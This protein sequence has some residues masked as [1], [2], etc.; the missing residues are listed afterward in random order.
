MMSH[1]IV[2]VNCFY[3]WCLVHGQ[4]VAVVVGFAC[5]I[6]NLIISN[7][8]VFQI[9]LKTLREAHTCILYSLFCMLPSLLAF[10]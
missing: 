3:F 2:F 7:L 4:A 10:S 1:G 8:L 6:F 5:S 9:D